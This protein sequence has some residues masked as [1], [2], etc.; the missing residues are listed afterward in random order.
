LD[1]ADRALA[2]G[3]VGSIRSRI[4]RVMD[5]RALRKSTEKWKSE[6]RALKISSALDATIEELQAG[7]KIDHHELLRV[8]AETKRKLDA[9]WTR[10]CIPPGRRHRINVNEAG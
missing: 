9:L 2:V 10:S 5:R 4:D 6:M 1:V 3:L 8:F 7:K